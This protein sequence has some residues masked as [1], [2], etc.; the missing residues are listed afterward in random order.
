MDRNVT[1]AHW[2]S[3]TGSL[4]TLFALLLAV[5][6][7]MS[8]VPAAGTHACVG[9]HGLGG[10]RPLTS[11]SGEPQPEAFAEPT[12][13]SAFQ[14]AQPTSDA[15]NYTLSSTTIRFRAGSYTLF[16]FNADTGA[17][18]KQRSV[19][20]STAVRFKAAHKLSTFADTSYSRLTSGTWSGWYARA[21][22]A[23]PSALT[24][25]GETRQVR[26]AKGTHT[27]V[28]FYNNS[29]LTV[30]RSA[31]LAGADV[32]GVSQ[33]ATFNNR[34]WF[35]LADG[36]L[37]NR[38]VKKSSSVSL[39]S[40][41]TS[42]S[43]APALAPATWKA[44]VLVYRDTDVT[45]TRSDGSTYRLRAH[46]TD[47]MYNLSREVIDKFVN[48]SA[49]WS[50]GFTGIDLT[51]VN[52]PRTLD[53]IEPLSGG[54]YWVAPKSVKPDMDKYAPAGSYDSVFV[55]WEAKDSAGVRVPTGGWGLTVAPGAWAN[56]AGF[57]S[58]HTPA[59]YWWWDVKY[60]QEVFVHEW[61]HQVLFFHENGGRLKLD[62]HATGQYGYGSVDGSYRA[63][64]SDVMRGLVEDGGKLLGVNYE[65]WRAASP[66]RPAGWTS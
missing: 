41:D 46:M 64:L 25:F 16:R 39:V 20:F 35:L 47:K 19:R 15:V 30:R 60:P 49:N 9:C 43:T 51:V 61:M 55:L 29:R 28:R 63:W 22:D 13:A 18:L 45:F 11:L 44:I 26:L 6:T 34:T 36:P 31:T 48:S 65:I 59:E 12:S 66:T 33:R 54:K 40:S 4:V 10:T 62:L 27:G 32:F 7:N 56:G 3:R 21:N 50:G 1:P 14:V 38:W 2:R 57:S 5:A 24:A 23:A 42:D 52:V 8:S 58:I 37:A 53:R 17:M